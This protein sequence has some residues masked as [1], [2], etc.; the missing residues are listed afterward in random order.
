M[1]KKIL[2]IITLVVISY[3]MGVDAK[4]DLDPSFSI[5]IVGVYSGDT[6]F[7]KLYPL[8]SPLNKIA[9]T[10]RGVESPNIKTSKCEIEKQLARRIKEFVANRIVNS[11]SIRL[12]KVKWGAYS[13]MLLADVILDG[14]NLTDTLIQM[15]YGVPYYGGLKTGDWCVAI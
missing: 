15:G 11:K 13:G 9:I 6:L 1:L 4:D 3:A 2:F 7:A 12:K 10:V 14:E 8:P 5:E